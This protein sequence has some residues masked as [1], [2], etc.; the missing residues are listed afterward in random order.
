MRKIDALIEHA[1]LITSDALQAEMGGRWLKVWRE[2]WRGPYVMA[3]GEPMMPADYGMTFQDID[4]LV[5][6]MR[7]IADLRRWVYDDGH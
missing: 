6:A 7:E 1:V 2:E 3:A 5:K 4:E